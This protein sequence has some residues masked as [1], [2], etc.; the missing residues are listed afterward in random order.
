MLGGDLA[1]LLDDF[2]SNLTLTRVTAGDYDPS[3]GTVGAI[4]STTYHI[5]GVFID[6]MDSDVDGSVVRRGDR[7][8]LIRASDAGTVPAV[9]DRVGGLQ[10]LSVQTIAPKGVPIGWICHMR[11]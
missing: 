8:L 7:K 11:A 3:L 6:Y 2:G 4:T 10:V 1:Y 5:H 9:S